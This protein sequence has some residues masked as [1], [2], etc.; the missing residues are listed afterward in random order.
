MG[1]RADCGGRHGASGHPPCR[2]TGADPQLR[3]PPPTPARTSL[4]EKK[5]GG[6]GK[7]KGPQ[8]R[9]HKMRAQGKDVHTH[10]RTRASKKERTPTAHTART[11]WLWDEKTQDDRNR[12]EEPHVSGLWIPRTGAAHL[13]PPL[14]AAG[15]RRGNPKKKKYKRQWIM[16]RRTAARGPRSPRLPL[17]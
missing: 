9:L 11:S 14:V 5:A 4:L 6:G 12:I 13:R 16:A 3:M 15:Q 17:S 7:G 10:L 2:G 8:Q 1:A